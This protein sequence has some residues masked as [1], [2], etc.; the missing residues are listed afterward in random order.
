MGHLELLKLVI[1]DPVKYNE[2]V[3]SGMAMFRGGR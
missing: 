3:Q 1:G 2:E